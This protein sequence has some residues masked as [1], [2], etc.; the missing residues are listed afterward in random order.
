MRRSIAVTL[1]LASGL[2]PLAP[3]LSL[4]I[5]GGISA[6]GIGVG[7]DVGASSG[8]VGVGAGVSAGSLG[9]VGVGAGASPGGVSAGGSAAVGGTG[10]GAAAG[11]GSQGS[12]PGSS[13]SS[14]GVSISGEASIGGPSAAAGGSRSSGTGGSVSQGVAS[15]ATGAAANGVGSLGSAASTGQSLSGTGPVDAAGNAGDG[16]RQSGRATTTASVPASAI[17]ATVSPRALAAGTPDGLLQLPLKLA[18]VD[19]GSDDRT[20]RR[21][22]SPLSTGS[23]RA[24]TSVP[25]TPPRVVTACR[26]ALSES[27]AAYGAVR[28]DVAS[29]ARPRRST[30]GGLSAPMEARIVYARSR[31]VQVRQARVTCQFDRDGQ[32]VA[33]L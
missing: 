20:V 19:E 26:N 1:L 6:G 4:D 23:L 25:G 22:R 24:L 8:G 9:D 3:S 18:P 5:G 11:I 27:A 7:A 32:V 17:P 30:N 21:A 14:G 2:I 15:G 12:G 28:V 33:A 29:T 13:P 10:A 31:G 16:S